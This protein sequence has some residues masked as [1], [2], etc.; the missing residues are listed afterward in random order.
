MTSFVGIKKQCIVECMSRMTGGG[1]AANL[2]PY[3]NRKNQCV[4]SMTATYI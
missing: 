3:K 2:S 4:H 1:G